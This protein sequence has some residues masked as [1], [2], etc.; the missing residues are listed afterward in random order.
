MSQAS[1][2]GAA[3]PLNHDVV[4]WTL[5][6]QP[7]RKDFTDA[8]IGHIV[9][10][11]AAQARIWGAERWTYSR[12]LAPT[13]PSVQVRVLASPG[14]FERLQ[15]FALALVQ[16]SAPHLGEVEISISGSDPV[17][18]RWNTEPVPAYVEAALAKFGG[19]EG[20]ALAAEVSE[21]GSDLAVWAVARFPG[22]NSRSPLAALLLHDSCHAMMRGPRSSTW[23]DRRAV[24]WDFYWDAHLRSCTAS[25]GSE[26]ARR[27]DLLTGQLAPRVPPAHRLM[28][29][30]ASEPA[31]A[32]WRRRW[33]KAIDSYLYRADKEKVSRSALHLTMYQTSQ[34]LN[35]LGITLLDQAALGLFA[36]TWSRD[37]EADL[38]AGRSGGR[39]NGRPADGEPA[40]R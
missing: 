27:R 7:T 29:A 10:P 34:L 19:L 1:T 5:T 13:N 2:A 11:F 4:W 37:R 6:I 21:L 35:R 24:S 15:S 30:T 22:A 17:P 23:P 14:V 12:H 18:T 33:S 39:R 20:I 36:R 31:V 3:N 40:S 26:A 38:L 9:T 25:L 28:A 32:N 8:V 16:L